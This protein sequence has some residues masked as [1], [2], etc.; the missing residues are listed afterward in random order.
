MIRNLRGGWEGRVLWLLTIALALVGQHVLIP[1]YDDD[2][3]LGLGLFGLAGLGLLALMGRA[4]T[5]EEPER[6]M[7]RLARGRS[8]WALWLNVGLAVLNALLVLWLLRDRRWDAPCWDALVLWGAS[9]VLVL[10]AGLT[11]ENHW[12]SLRRLGGWLLA[13]W[14]ELVLVAGVTLV[15]LGLRAVALDAVPAT[16]GG[17]EGSQGL[18]ALRFLDGRL[19]NMFVTGWLGVPTMSFLV[20]AV[21]VGL[22]GNTAFGLRVLWALV[23]AVTLPALYVLARLLF[24]DRRIAIIATIFLAGYHY[25]IHYSR[26]GSNQI[27]DGLFLTVALAALVWGLQRGSATAFAVSGLVAGLGMY[28]YAGARSV[29]LV[30]GAV[31]VLVALTAPRDWRVPWSRLALLV[32]GFLVAAAPMLLFAVQHPS[33]FSARINAVGI[34]QSGWLAREPGLT[35]KPLETILAEQF[36][37]ATLAFNHYWDR[38]VW[39]GLRAP[40]LDLVAGALAVLGFVYALAH[41]RERRYAIPVLWLASVVVLGGALT[42]NPP[43]SQ[44]LTGAAPALALLVAVGVARLTDLGRDLWGRPVVWRVVVPVLTVWLLVA[45]SLRTYFVDYTPLQIYGGENAQVATA[46]GVYLR[47]HPAERAVYFFGAPRLYF[48]FGSI[49]YLAP[50]A[51]GRD[52][53]EPLAG[54]PVFV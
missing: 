7:P 18:E 6:P 52:V 2:L 23:G 14:G 26:L 41:W 5:L 37:H 35:G 4:E 8:H 54:P 50:E 48:G 3:G 19:Q 29:P 12:P 17:D 21:T 32:L 39:Y 45:M 9:M 25:H 13:H 33:D 10:L 38:V 47:N 51:V 42:E 34:V 15:G 20:Q 36:L 27:A 31:L 1:T 22:F 30:L 11:M 53:T 28:F 16:L 49:G 43:S 46:L 40:L 24:D 44:R